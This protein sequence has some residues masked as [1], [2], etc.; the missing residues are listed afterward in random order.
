M[1]QSNLPESSAS[2]HESASEG[3]KTSKSSNLPDN[4]EMTPEAYVKTIG[5]V[6]KDFEK[7]TS[8]CSKQFKKINEVDLFIDDDIQVQKA[9]LDL[10]KV[11][12]NLLNKFFMNRNLIIGLL[13]QNLSEDI[14]IKLEELDTKF[15]N[16]SDKYLDK[17]SELGNS[18]TLKSSIKE[19]Y[20]ETNAFRKAASKEL[21]IAESLV[22][23][24]AKT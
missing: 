6:I 18:K 20:I 23:R 8:D 7:F 11:Q 17:I 5:I 15:Q 4:D 2:G 10:L 3:N 14:K 24:S 19:F 22:Q 13:A 9:I 16:S 12:S 1:E 21:N